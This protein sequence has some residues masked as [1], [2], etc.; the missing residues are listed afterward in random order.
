MIQSLFVTEV[1]EQ[2]V[3]TLL[4][5]LGAPRTRALV[6]SLGPGLCVLAEALRSARTPLITWSCPEV[7][8]FSFSTLYIAA[9]I[10][11]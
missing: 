7:S 4:A 1:C 6:G 9:R 10:N 5:A 3:A 2:G 11:K 8:P